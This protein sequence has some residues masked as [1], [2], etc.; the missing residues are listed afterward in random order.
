MIDF[1]AADKKMIYR[2]IV[3]AEKLGLRR[4][5][6]CSEVKMISDSSGK[7]EYTFGA[8]F[9]EAREKRPKNIKKNGDACSLCGAV[10]DARKDSNLIVDDAQEL[11]DFIVV[12]N[13]FP[14]MT[15]H[16]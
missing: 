16:S 12:P 13:L 8:I 5:N 4:E 1:P 10:E 7:S 11:D 2:W 6:Y 14:L 15:G 3:A 9:N